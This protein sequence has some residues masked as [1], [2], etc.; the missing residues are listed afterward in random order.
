MRRVETASG[1]R[2][3]QIVHSQRRGSREI[4]LIGSAHTDAG[5]ELV[6]AVAGQRLAVAQQ[7]LVLRLPDSPVNGG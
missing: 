5:V 4:E 3:A 2:M 6:K 7:E 1:A